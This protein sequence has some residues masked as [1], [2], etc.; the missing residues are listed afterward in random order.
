MS[1]YRSIDNIAIEILDIWNREFKGQWRTKFFG[2]VPYLE[3]MIYLRRPEDNYGSDSAI[4]IIAKFLNN[5]SL[6]KGEDARRIKKELNNVLNS[7]R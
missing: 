3:T 5:I 2:A 1:G 4:E 6:W 7:Q